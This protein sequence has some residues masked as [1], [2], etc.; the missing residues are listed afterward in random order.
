M[1]VV[2]LYQE[3]GVKGLGRGV[4][5]Y[6]HYHIP[7]VT[8]YVYGPIALKKLTELNTPLT[9]ES[10]VDYV[11]TQCYS[12]ITP[13]QVRSE[14]LRLV[15]LVSE[16]KPKVIL[17]IGT[18]TGGTLFL[19]AQNSPGNCLLI[20]VDLPGGAFGGGYP[21]WKI[22][23]Y[24]AFALHGQTIRLF[25]A[26]SHACLTLYFV[27]H[28]IKGGIDFLFIDGDHTYEGVK[29]D[30]ETYGPLVRK[31][32]F[33]AFHDIV[34]HPKETGCEVNRFWNE[35]KQGRKCEEMVEDWGQGSCGIGVIYV[36]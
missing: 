32:G 15:R 18:A 5:R 20:S 8:R 17:E 34:E 28:A 6:I 22:P 27:R 1:G 29:K 31:G 16:R 12:L 26:D 24:K 9:P 11:N 30:F 10:S 36:A 7:L 33:V 21:E 35:V 25:R 19:F 13:I 2:K 3:E 4:E 14:I 23:L